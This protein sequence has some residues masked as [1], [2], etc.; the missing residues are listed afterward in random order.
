MVPT[1]HNNKQTNEGLT[2]ANTLAEDL[3]TI[4]IHDKHSSTHSAGQMDGMNS[5]ERTNKQKSEG[6]CLPLDTINIQSEY[7]QTNNGLFSCQ[8]PPPSH[9]RYTSRRARGRTNQSSINKSMKE[10]FSVGGTNQYFANLDG[11]NCKKGY[12][13]TVSTM[14]DQMIKQKNKLM[15]ALTR[16]VLLGV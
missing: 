10:Q 5:S 1:A 12:G 3:E 13:H 15:Y 6:E 9:F 2:I 8:D 16:Q 7:E 14:D 4:S 11:T